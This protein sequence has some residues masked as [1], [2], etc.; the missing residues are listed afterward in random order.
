MGGFPFLANFGHEDVVRKAL[1]CGQLPWEI[2]PEHYDE[3]K[4]QAIQIN[5]GCCH[6]WLGRHPYEV[7]IGGRYP[8]DASVGTFESFM[9]LRWTVQATQIYKTYSCLSRGK[10]IS[11]KWQTEQLFASS[12]R[13]QIY[14]G[15]ECKLQN[16]EW[17]SFCMVPANFGRIAS[18]SDSQN[19]T[20]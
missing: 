20:D 18:L 3:W 2:S 8:Y 13:A 16:T 19:V 5:E 17:S 4:K 7:G 1:S 14:I 15:L 11:E 12:A 10:W 6:N 9:Y